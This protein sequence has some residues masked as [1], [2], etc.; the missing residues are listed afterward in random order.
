MNIYFMKKSDFIIE[1]NKNYMTE[2][3]V[4][5]SF[6]KTYEKLYLDIVKK[7]KDILDK[8]NKGYLNLIKNKIE[9]VD[10]FINQVIYEKK[11]KLY[12]L[13]N[14]IKVKQSKY[15]YNMTNQKGSVKVILP[16]TDVMFIYFIYLFIIY[17]Y[18]S[19]F[20]E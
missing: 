13:L 14:D 7:I 16:Y 3:A 19:F 6:F 18:F 8:I 11:V 4:L 9:K 15:E 5:S 20:Y 17:D 10:I 2:D 12:K 1:L